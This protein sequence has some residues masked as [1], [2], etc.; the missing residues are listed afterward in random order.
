MGRAD[1][2]SVRKADPNERWRG[3]RSSYSSLGFQ[4]LILRKAGPL[5]QVLQG[6][7]WRGKIQTHLSLELQQWW[8]MM[9]QILVLLTDP[10]LLEN[11]ATGRA[12]RQRQREGKRQ[13]YILL[14]YNNN[15]NCLTWLG[16]TSGRLWILLL[17]KFQNNLGSLNIH[18]L[19]LFSTY[20]WMQWIGGPG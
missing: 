20:R 12:K 3:R 19:C 2:F 10:K 16:I 6:L 13:Q 5:A 15:K 17:S 1:H 8:R 7:L 9:T 14:V 4:L 18:Q 11:Q